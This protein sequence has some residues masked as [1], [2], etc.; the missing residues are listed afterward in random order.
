[1]LFPKYNTHV[2]CIKNARA[3]FI[4]SFIKEKGSPQVVVVAIFCNGLNFSRN[5][6][7]KREKNKA[8]ENKEHTVEKN[9]CIFYRVDA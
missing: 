6:H 2:N 8:R 9:A 5:T 3:Q 7:T 1:M 4:L